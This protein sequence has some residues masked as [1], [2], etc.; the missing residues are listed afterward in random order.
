MYA[1]NYIIIFYKFENQCGNVILMTLI[2]RD[3]TV[4]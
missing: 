4:F 1:T 2:K 3:P